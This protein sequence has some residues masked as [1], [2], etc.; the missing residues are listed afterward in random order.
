MLSLKIVI[1]NK[2][3]IM[4]KNIEDKDVK[5]NW[6][7]SVGFY[8]GVLIGGRTYEEKNQV[9]HVLYL[10]FIDIALEIFN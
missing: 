7:L 4:S 8:P 5:D 2:V 1:V 6:S 3:K 10:P 9:T